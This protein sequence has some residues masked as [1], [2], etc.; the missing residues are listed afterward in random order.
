[1]IE[2]ARDLAAR[3][4]AAAAEEVNAQLAHGAE[5]VSPFGPVEG[6]ADL[7]GLVVTAAVKASHLDSLDL[8]HSALAGFGQFSQAD[9]ANCRFDGA[10]LETNL[11]KHFESCSF[12]G[13]RLVG[14]VL[15]GSFENCTFVGANLSG[16]RGRE[17]VFRACDFS[18]ANLKK[19]HLL[20]CRWENCCFDH[21]QFHGGSLW[22]STFFGQEPQSSQ[23]GNTIL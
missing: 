22:K 2:S 9:F 17:L 4:T 10:T 6:R 23:L 8:A 1:M 12:I 20:H 3:W 5:A 11:G 15:R 16:S 7:R 13:A 19:A 18:R 14:A 21:T